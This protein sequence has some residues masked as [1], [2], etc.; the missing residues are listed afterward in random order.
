MKK[1]L[2]KIQDN[3]QLIV[4]ASVGAGLTLISANFGGI[5]LIVG[6][7]FIARRLAKKVNDDG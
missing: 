4:S 2:K 7:L 5:M 3:E 6:F 1:L